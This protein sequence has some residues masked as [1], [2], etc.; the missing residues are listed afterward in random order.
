MS[1]PHRRGAPKA[2]PKQN[3]P[4]P[5]LK[6]GQLPIAAPVPISP[7]A[8]TPTKHPVHPKYRSD[9]DGL[10]A[11]AVVS[12]VVFHAFPGW[13]R[14]GFIGVDIFFVISGFLISTIIFENLEKGTFSFRDFY[15][16]RIRRILPALLVV[17]LAT[18]S[19]GWFV[20]LA[21][22]Y[23]QLGNHMA[24]A[25]G[26]VA[27]FMFAAENGYFDNAAETKPLLHLWSLGVEE[28][29]YLLWPVLA[30]AAWKT[31]VN[32]LAFTIVVAV[33]SFA[34]NMIT[35][36]RDS[37]SAFYLPQT[38]FW[39]LLI[40]AALAYFMLRRASGAKEMPFPNILSLLGAL[41]IGTGL[42]VITRETLYPGWWAM[43]PTGGSALM[44]S[45]GTKAWINRV[46]LSNRIMVMLGLISYPLYLWHWPLLSLPHI[47]NGQLPPVQ[48][49]AYAVL[50]SILLAGATFWFVEKRLRFKAG[51]TVIVGLVAALMVVGGIGYFTFVRDGLTL[52]TAANPV[53]VHDGDIDHYLYHDYAAKKFYP[54]TPLS[55][56]QTA[57]SFGN[58]LRCLQSKDQQPIDIA[59]IGDSH[60]EQL[61]LGLA[62]NL[63]N[64]NITFYL[65]TT[66]PVVGDKDFEPIFQYVLSDRSIKTVVLCAYWSSKLGFIPKGSNLEAEL[67]A[68][69]VKLAEAN[70]TVYLA[71]DIP[72]YLFDPKK[73]KYARRFNST[74]TCVE[75][76]ALFEQQRHYYYPAFQAVQRSHPFVKLL[77]TA[78]Y[79]CD[80]RFCS[81]ERDGKVIYRDTNHLNLIGT[82][83]VAKR[84]LED[85]PE[86]AHLQ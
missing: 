37:G 68:T 48:V 30:W 50:I 42:F 6:P 7:P 26:F 64:T 84:I 66:L 33:T 76:R 8:P 73:C 19:I 24:G 43:L 46:I 34:V 74:T 20:L 49:R 17:I 70:K 71:D 36:K 55:I 81:M 3:T 41:L 28:Q 39:E 44:I 75:D 21:A 10:R 82:R 29:F 11:V 2:K 38:R 18:Y 85:N 16:R 12:V 67:S 60:A 61:F 1:R 5:I 54:C 31:R 52:R 22:E 83:Y 47:V 53:V 15:S 78:E 13:L 69:A 25:A 35:V 4:S 77:N 58:A 80:A 56:R 40:G 51:R 57:L 59:L 45:A 65:K 23:K 72:A 79:F 86:F 63:P 9:I 62:E 14:G 27:N 32:L